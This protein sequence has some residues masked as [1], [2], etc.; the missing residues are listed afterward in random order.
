[1]DEDKEPEWVIL[2]R[3]LL[4]EYEQKEVKLKIENKKIAWDAFQSNYVKILPGL[5][6]KLK[7]SS[8]KPGEWFGKPGIGFD[9]LI[10]DGQKVAKQFTVVSL[11]LIK[12]LRPIILNAEEKGKGCH[13]GPYFTHGGWREYAVYGKRAPRQLKR[14]PWRCRMKRECE[15]TACEIR[16]L[17]AKIDQKISHL[18]ETE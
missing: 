17:L 8:W 1:M 15:K 18:L 14:S 10:E 12:A 4:Q 6:K 9:V 5:E 11:P 2:L 3:N 16:D 7:L 13:T